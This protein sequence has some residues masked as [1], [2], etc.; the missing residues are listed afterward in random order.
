MKRAACLILTVCVC[1]AAV[2]CAS[3]PARGPIRMTSRGEPEEP[4]RARPVSNSDS[5]ARLEVLGEPPVEE[6]AAPPAVEDDGDPEAEEAY[7][8]TRESLGELS[9]E[10]DGDG[11]EGVL[12]K[13]SKRSP[14]VAEEAEGLFVSTWL[15][16]KQ[17]IEIRMAAES[18]GG[19]F[20]VSSMVARAPSKRRTSKG[21]GL[22]S[23]PEAIEEAYGKT[24]THVEETSVRVGSMYGGLHFELEDGKVRSIFI[25]ASAE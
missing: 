14:V 1:S 20:R 5:E 4:E 22:G 11:V 7:D 15:W 6:E 25:G 19:P 18:K 9:F 24:L 13:P 12:G 16:P 10:L 3:S 2:A 8:F 17:G 21:I 23:T